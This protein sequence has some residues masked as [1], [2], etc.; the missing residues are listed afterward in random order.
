MLARIGAD[1]ALISI[2]VAGA[3]YVSRR[4][5]TVEHAADGVGVTMRA[6]ST[7][8]TDTSV[9]SMAQQTGLSMRAETDK[10]R[11]TV[12]TCGALAACSGSTVVNVFRAVRSAPAIDA[13]AHIAA[14]KVAARSSILASVWLQATLIHILCA[15]L[16][17][18]LWRTLTVVGVNSVHTGSPIGTLMAWAVINVVLTVSPIKSWQAVA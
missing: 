18:P 1:A 6:L 13:H 2:D 5:V 12:D 4:T 16:T 7:R 14:N 10:R 15:V 3:A 8:V 11:H 9:I 17:S